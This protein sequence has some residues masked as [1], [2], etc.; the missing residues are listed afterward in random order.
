M[1]NFVPSAPIENVEARGK[2][3]TKP[4]SFE[5][6]TFSD[7]GRMRDAGVKSQIRKHAMK[8]IG[9]TRRRPDKRRRGCIELL[10]EL[11]PVV[12][13]PSPVTTSVGSNAIDP[14][15]RYPVELGHVERELVANSK[16]VRIS[17]EPVVASA[18]NTL[19][20]CIDGT[21]CS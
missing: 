8:D 2:Q 17:C 11:M 7:V 21:Q 15:L 12:T 6:V 10:V 20:R 19:I 3:M 13:A 4:T 18:A 1:I 9:V 14:F 5:F 16:F